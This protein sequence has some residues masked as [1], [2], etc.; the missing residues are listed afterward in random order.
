M[1]KLSTIRSILM[2]PRRRRLNPIVVTIIVPDVTVRHIHMG[3]AV[4]RIRVRI[5]VR[6]PVRLIGVSIGVRDIGVP[7]RAVC[8]RVVPVRPVLRPT[9]RVKQVIPST[10]ILLFCAAASLC[11]FCK[12]TRYFSP[13]SPE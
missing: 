4:R 8:V 12:G 6:I 1:V 5:R 7:T 13:F 2:I 9:N 11:T 10:Q 3:I